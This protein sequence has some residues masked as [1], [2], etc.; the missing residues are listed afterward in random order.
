L[1][2]F[3]DTTQSPCATAAGNF[4]EG[5][6][7]Q[8][9]SSHILGGLLTAAGM[10]LSASV[11]MQ[12]LPAQTL[13]VIHTFKGGTTDGSEPYGTPLLFNGDLYGTTKG[14]GTN[15][16]GTVYEVNFATKDSAILHSFAGSPSD[17]AEPLAGLILDTAGNLYGTTFEG[18]ASGHGTVF[19]VGSS[20]GG[21]YTVL[22]SLA[23]PPAEG[24]GPAGPLAFD[25][26]Y[27]LYGTTYQG[28]SAKYGTTFE[29]TTAD[30]FTTG[31]DF[32][33]GGALP[34]GGLTGTMSGGK[35]YGTTSG[36]ISVSYGGTIFETNNSAALYTFTG[37]ADGAAPMAGLIEDS[38]GNLYGTCSAGGSA[39]FGL[40][41]GTVFEYST[42]TSK[43]TVLHTFSGPDGS[44]PMASLFRDSEGNLYGTTVFGGASGNG[45]VFKL[46]ATGTFTTVY[47]FTGGA[48]GARPQ[49]GVIVD[50]K[51]DIF[52]SASGG[53]TNGDGT[54]F[55]ITSAS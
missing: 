55:V 30:V 45:T 16:A 15:N 26:S 42:T 6:K 40:G 14:G 8:N 52:G 19:E 47:S 2:P 20:P 36:G 34:H 41:N 49:S 50:S 46:S 39:N 17:G 7:M 1:L 32:P 54:L 38:E 28:G 21:K 10:A 25:S 12:P 23:G 44:A 33:P 22:H 31:Q 35:F 3:L 18:G 53:G 43:L 5:D 13:T 29:L 24:S 11:A 4:L 51:G 27:N 9:R 48:D 37:G